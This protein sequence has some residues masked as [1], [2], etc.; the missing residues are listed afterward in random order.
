MKPFPHV[1]RGKIPDICKKFPLIPAKSRQFP[2]IPAKP[3]ILDTS[4]F[5][6]GFY[7]EKSKKPFPQTTCVPRKNS[8]HMQEIPANSR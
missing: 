6:R 7:K 4:G 8:R 2:T 1:L 5:A 3:S